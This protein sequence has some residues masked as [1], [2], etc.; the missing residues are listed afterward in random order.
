MKHNKTKSLTFCWSRRCRK[1]GAAAQLCYKGF[2]TF[3]SAIHPELIAAQSTQANDFRFS[4]QIDSQPSVGGVLMLCGKRC[5]RRYYK[6][7]F[8]LPHMAADPD[9][10]RAPGAPF[11]SRAWGDF[12]PGIP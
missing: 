11:V 1:A 12:S 8:L 6:R 4:I 7:S 5:G 3:A 2:P 9:E 10:R